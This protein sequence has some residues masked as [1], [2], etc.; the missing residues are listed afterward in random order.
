MSSELAIT[1][2]ATLFVAIGP[3]D[4]AIV[5]GGLTAGV[6]RPERFPLAW[7]AVMIAGVVLLGFAL[8]GNQVLAALRVSL[9]AFRVAGGILLLLQAIQ[10][11]FA[12]PAGLS[13]LTASERREAMGPGDIAIFPLAF[14]V[15]AGPAGLTAVVLLMGQANGDPLSSMIVLGAMFLCLFLT[16]IGMIF[17]DVLHNLLKATGSNVLARLAGVILAALA[18]QFIFDGIRGARL[19]AVG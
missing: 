4:T 2:F 19:V 13:S 5:F 15:I 7:Q 3:I 10:M 16:Y 14:P 9:D 18:V 12:Q 11:I 8:F 17:T 6:H 1:A